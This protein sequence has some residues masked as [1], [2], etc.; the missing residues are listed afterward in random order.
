MMAAHVLIGRIVTKENTDMW[1]K[2]PQPVQMGTL[3]VAAST[4]PVVLVEVLVG[5]T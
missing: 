1:D 5:E 2:L 4:V 3:S